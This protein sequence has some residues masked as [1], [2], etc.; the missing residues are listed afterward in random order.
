MRR[1]RER[2]R[3]G[4]DDACRDG[5]EV[6]S[7][8]RRRGRGRRGGG[9]EAPQLLR[10]E[11]VIVVSGPWACQRP[12]GRSSTTRHRR[13]DQSS[14]HDESTNSSS[15]R[16]RGAR[17]VRDRGREEE[18]ARRA[19]LLTESTTSRYRR[20]WERRRRRSTRTRITAQTATR[21][22]RAA[23]GGTAG[24]YRRDRRPRLE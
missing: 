12:R 21:N 24:R 2:R 14:K 11:D 13:I 18:V 16:T 23:W 22:R 19:P 10:A 20:G 4:W 5:G 3:R 9:W 17:R 1:N 6:P 7:K 15:G 8:R